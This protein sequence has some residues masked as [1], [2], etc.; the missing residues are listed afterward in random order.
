MRYPIS[1]LCLAVVAL[2]ACAP[3]EEAEEPVDRQAEAEAIMELER[4]WSAAFQEGDIDWIVDL[5]AANGRTLPPGSEP[6]VGPE[7]VRQL[8]TSLY[9][10]E[11]L[12]LTFGP[13]EAHV[14][15]A[16]D[17]GYALGTYE[18]TLPDGT[19]D[20]GKYVVVWVKE[21]GEWKVAA[22]IFNSNLPAAGG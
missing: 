1:V 2:T 8:W 11:G 7:A 10:T 19:E 15:E 6:F 5:H 9:R 4:Q 12:S 18:M 21:A 3:A 22:D 20:R 13:T 14:A 16:G 17:L